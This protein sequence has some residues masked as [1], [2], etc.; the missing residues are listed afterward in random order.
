MPI[1]RIS[2]VITVDVLV[3]APVVST[4]ELRAI[5]DCEEALAKLPHDIDLDSV[6]VTDRSEEGYE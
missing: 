2:L 1:Y 5:S 3:N 6:E 4:A